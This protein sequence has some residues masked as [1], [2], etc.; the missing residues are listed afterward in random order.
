MAAEEPGSCP[1]CK[2]QIDPEATRC[3]SCGSRITPTGPGHGGTCPYCKE[4]IHPEAVV[5]KHCRSGLRPGGGAHGDGPGGC[6]CSGRHGG[7]L[8]TALP[9]S[10]GDAPFDLAGLIGGFAEAGGPA[11]GGPSTGAAAR[12]PQCTT[13][14]RGSTL[15]CACPVHIPGFGTGILIYACGTCINDPVLTAASSPGPQ[16][17]P[18]GGCC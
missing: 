8:A 2:E 4:A 14:C 16:G 3:P 13:W 15:M 9:R 11:P 17:R 5:C 10:A 1:Y 7:P 18:S 6:T 12:A